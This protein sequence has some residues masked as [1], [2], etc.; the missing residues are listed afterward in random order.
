M[1]LVTLHCMWKVS[2]G[3]W[4]GNGKTEFPNLLTAMLTVW[5]NTM[6]S[7]LGGP[8]R[9]GGT[10]GPIRVTMPPPPQTTKCPPYAPTEILQARPP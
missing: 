6:D 5:E 7:L 8:L 3:G 9:G 10:L 1:M 2:R 4:E